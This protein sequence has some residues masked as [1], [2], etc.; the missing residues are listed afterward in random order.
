MPTEDD[1]KE[2]EKI[3]ML[4]QLGKITA[5]QANEMKRD[6][7]SR[8]GY[9]HTQ[10]SR[11][12]GELTPPMAIKDPKVR[13]A[14]NQG[15]NELRAYAKYLYEKELNGLKAKTNA[16][17]KKTTEAKNALKDAWDKADEFL[18]EKK[19]G[20]LSDIAGAAAAVPIPQAKAVG[21]AATLLGA[22]GQQGGGSN[23]KAIIIKEMLNERFQ[24]Y[25]ECK[26]ELVELLDAS[27]N[28]QYA[29]NTMRE[30]LRSKAKQIAS[31]IISDLEYR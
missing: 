29:L 18:K 22:L 24:E 11:V 27:K 13:S 5:K 9:S 21:I 6:V 3:N 30:N 8:K 31:K 12:S 2:I 20:G 23:E 26:K 14:L 15:R 19:G 10:L 28:E 4:L 17:I 16:S 25:Q 7:L 1:M